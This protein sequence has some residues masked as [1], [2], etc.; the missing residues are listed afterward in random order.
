MLLVSKGY[1][2]CGLNVS[3]GNYLLKC[4]Y[5]LLATVITTLTSFLYQL[6]IA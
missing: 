6:P 4:S 3:L 5:I 2:T 1:G